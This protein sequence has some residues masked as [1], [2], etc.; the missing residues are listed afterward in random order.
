LRRIAIDFAIVIAAALGQLEKVKSFLNEDGSLVA[1]LPA[2][3]NSFGGFIGI[4]AQREE[5]LICASLFGQTRVVDFLLGIGIDPCAADGNGQTA[6]HL[7]A[8][9][10][11]LETVNLLLARNTALEIRNI[12]GGT[13][14][15]QAVWSA[16]NEPKADHIAIIELL[17]GA[18]A[19]V[20]A[21]GYPTGKER[22]DEVL[23]RF[24]AKSG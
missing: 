23:R 9:S 18:G 16:L 5:A 10:G 3:R 2:L 22:L 1:N 4:E 6:C 14:R 15:G 19:K 20:E 13:V 11:H 24:G 17:L 7:A 8:H 12:F 21:A